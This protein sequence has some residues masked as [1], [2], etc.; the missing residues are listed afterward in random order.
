L[1]AKVVVSASLNS[2]QT[3][4]W[5]NIRIIRRP[6]TD[7]QIAARKRQTGKTS[8]FLAAV[9]SGRICRGKISLMSST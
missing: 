6:D 7:E 8:W 1:I 9:Q 3:A 5:H 4:P 2:G